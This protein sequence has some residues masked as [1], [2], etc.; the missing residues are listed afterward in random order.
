MILRILLA[1]ISFFILSGSVVFAETA[2]I[3]TKENALRE[4]CR[5]FSPAKAKLQYADTVTLI[6]KEG[7]WYRVSFKGTEGCIHRNAIEEKSFSLSGMSGTEKRSATNAEVALAGKG[8]N[9]QIEG[10]YRHNHPDMNF[11]AVDLIERYAVSET[12]LLEFI[13]RGGLNRP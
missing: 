3:I 1:S 2:R 6:S 12:D 5:F 7:D 8:F 4:Q 13:N 11:R 10:S 9:P